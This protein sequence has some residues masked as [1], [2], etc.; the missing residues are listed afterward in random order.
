MGVCEDCKH[1]RHER[2]RVDVC[3]CPCAAP[4]RTVKALDVFGEVHDT[5]RTEAQLNGWFPR[6]RRISNEQGSLL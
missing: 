4:T 5:G 2:C 6:P 3:E 1:G